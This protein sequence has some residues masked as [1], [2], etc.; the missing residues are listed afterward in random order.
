MSENL[1]MYG[2][3][4][5]DVYA[6]L[7]DLETFESLDKHELGPYDA[8]VIDVRDERPHVVKRMS[9]PTLELIP[10][11]VGRGR[12]PIGVLAEPLA[13]GECTLVVIG[14]SGIEKSFKSAIKR[15]GMTSKRPLASEELGA[16]TVTRSL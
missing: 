1:I 15:G 14:Q 10:E 6:A 13:P 5:N 4:Y 2:A 12:P 8:A 3:V 9:R 11:L 7:A 16:I